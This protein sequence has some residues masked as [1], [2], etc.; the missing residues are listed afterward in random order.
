MT[1][2]PGEGAA[3]PLEIER[4]FLLRGLPPLPE[5]A[6]AHRIEQG[7]LEAGFPTAPPEEFA[8][9]RLRRWTRPDGRVERF[10]TTKRGSG[11][12]REEI[13]R[14][15]DEAEFAR[16]WPRTG[17]RRISKTR[18]RVPEGE[19][20]WEVDRFDDLPLVMAEVELP[21]VEHPLSIPAW[22]EG[23]IVREVSEDPRYR[24]SELARRI[25]AGEALPPL[26]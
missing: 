3:A 9:G 21:S 22:L 14:S 5:R 7:Y 13:E 26:A 15:I 24:N 11:I 17:R 20:I 16:A 18:H 23:W 10:H 19:L 8:E 1:P 12:V 4:V 25:A 2:R 6:E